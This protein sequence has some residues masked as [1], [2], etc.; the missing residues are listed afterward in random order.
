M[1]TFLA[2]PEEKRRAI[3]EGGFFCFGRMGYKKA[4][5]A[6][7]AESAGI[8]KATLFHYFGNKKNL[9]LFLVDTAFETLMSAFKKHYNS[10]LTDIFD[11]LLNLTECKVATLKQYPNLLLFLGEMSSETDP[12][13]KSEVDG[14][15]K[16]GANFRE[17]VFFSERDFEKFKDGVDPELVSK[18]LMRYSQGFF[19]SAS[20]LSIHELDQL[21]D[22]F[23]SCILMLKE[24]LY[25]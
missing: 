15:L 3:I 8:S 10:S 9:Y 25:K 14:V 11:R 13:V 20:N 12:E 23:T 4:S 17:G 22:E 16:K 21:S 6:D 7:I 24:N 18:L 5:T 19:Q 2:L 1:D